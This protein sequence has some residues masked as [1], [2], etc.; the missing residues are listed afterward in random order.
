[1]PLRTPFEKPIRLRH[2]RQDGDDDGVWG[3]H[4]EGD[5]GDV[6][7]GVLGAVKLENGR[8]LAAHGVLKGDDLEM[9]YVK[10]IEH[11]SYIHIYWDFALTLFLPLSPLYVF[12]FDL[13]QCL[14]FLS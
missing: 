13:F 2:L 5:V 4:G 7:E 12:I 9:E 3:H 10:G 8:A 6:V 14:Y 11:Y 1:M